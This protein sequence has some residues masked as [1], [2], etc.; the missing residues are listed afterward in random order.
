MSASKC[1]HEDSITYLDVSRNWVEDGKKRHDIDI[2]C[3]E[4]GATGVQCEEKDGEEWTFI[5]EAW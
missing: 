2:V 5:A 3:D 1:E 4:C